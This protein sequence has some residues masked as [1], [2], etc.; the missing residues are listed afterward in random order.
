MRPER[1]LWYGTSTGARLARGTL[2]GPSVA[3][4]LATRIRAGAYRA[5]LFATHRVARPVVAVGNLSVGGTGKTP[6]AAWIASWYAER[7]V[8]PAVVLRGYGQDEGEVHRDTTPDVL[9][10]EDPDRVRGARRAIRNGAQVIVLDDA[11][12]RL[13]IHRDLNIAVIGVESLGEPVDLLPAGPWREEWRALRRADVAVVTRRRATRLAAES[14]A[15]QVGGTMSLNRVAIAYLGISGFVRLRNGEA[16]GRDEVRGRRVFAACGIG[17]PDSF[18]AQLRELGALVRLRAWRDHHHYRPA[19]VRAVLSAG[20]EVD[21]VVVTAKDAVKLRRLWP[22]NGPELLVA[23]L[24]LGW[25]SGGDLMDEALSNVATTTYGDPQ[26]T[27]E[28]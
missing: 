26:G 3:Y 20:R 18:A 12:Q 21:Y 4:G 15:R 13:D 16:L 10:V 19:D 11:F 7:G 2:W 5:G 27:L 24:R 23:E 1:W 22:A 14:V 8:K 28:E 17:D 9:V 25:E 6:L